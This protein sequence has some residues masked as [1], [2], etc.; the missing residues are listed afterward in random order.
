M[1]ID[2]ETAAL[3]VIALIA[4]F[5]AVSA[6]IAIWAGRKSVRSDYAM[7]MRRENT[8]LSHMEWLLEESKKQIGTLLVENSELRTQLSEMQAEVAELKANLILLLNAV[9]RLNASEIT[10]RAVEAVRASVKDVLST[11][12]KKAS[13]KVNNDGGA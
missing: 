3:A 7:Q 8:T 1:K 9:E 13:H 11:A 12:K 5:T 2:T 10:Q 6:L 4:V